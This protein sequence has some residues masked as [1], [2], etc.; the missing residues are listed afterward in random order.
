[1]HCEDLMWVHAARL[2]AEADQRRTAE[3]LARARRAERRYRRAERRLHRA[4]AASAVRA[5]R[6]ASLGGRP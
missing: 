1:M 2:R 4:R 3:L 6:L 5:L